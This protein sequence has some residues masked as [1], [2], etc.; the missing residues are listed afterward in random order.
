MAAEKTPT[1]MTAEERQRRLT[2][3]A[4]KE[5]IASRDYDKEVQLLTQKLQGAHEKYQQVRQALDAERK[6]L[7]LRTKEREVQVR[8]GSGPAPYS[9]H[10]AEAECGWRPGR[11]YTL[12]ISEARARGLA[13]CS[14]CAKWSK[15]ND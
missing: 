3:L 15:F 8:K 5:R 10:Y 4:A 9:Y 7:K 11:F 12:P 6:Q 2:V 13:I 1:V 14:R